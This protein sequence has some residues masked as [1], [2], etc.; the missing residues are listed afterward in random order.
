MASVGASVRG[1]VAV[2][3][4]L[5]AGRL[6]RMISNPEFLL[7]KYPAEESALSQ[8]EGTSPGH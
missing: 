7:A 1:I 6:D 5:G 8:L 2:A 4:I 3:L